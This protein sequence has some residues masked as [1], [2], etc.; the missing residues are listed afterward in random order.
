MLVFRV[1]PHGLC[2]LPFC[3]RIHPWRRYQGGEEAR[4]GT[5]LDREAAPKRV[6]ERACEA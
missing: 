3:L 6:V 2:P 4:S 1:V 5:G